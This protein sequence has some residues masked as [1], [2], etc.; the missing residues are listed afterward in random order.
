MQIDPRHLSLLAAIVDA[1][2]VSEA[3]TRIGK[4]QPSLSRSVSLLEAR[5][6]ADLFEKG[7]RPL[8]PTE[9]GLALADEGRTI[10]R[11]TEAAAQTARN[12]T[13]GRAGTIRVGGTPVFMDGVISA[14][15]AAFQSEFTGLRVDQSYG[16]LDAL[17]TE[18]ERDQI[19]LAIC[20]I[21]RSEVPD[22]FEFQEL[23]PGRN[24]IVCGV[25]HPLSR[26]TSLR[27]DDIAPYPWIAPPADSPLF[28]DLRQT[29]SEI[30]ISDIRISFSGGSLAS[31]LNVL[32]GSDALAILPYTVVFAHRTT[33]R[34]HA[35]PIKISHPERSLGLLS[36]KGPRS[37]AASHFCSYLASLV[38]ALSR[39]IAEHERLQVWRV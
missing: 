15:I 5:L 6:G 24:V 28:R 29:L 34:L 12:H 25:G 10:A 30:G 23:L 38:K 22:G 18:L 11:A 35:L 20:P 36:R 33:G 2:G 21:P 26:K 27:L 8:R 4:S 37:P 16:Y 31:I 7:K 9:L 3:A 1:G 13:S 14:M 39:Q 17:M 32:A 19:D